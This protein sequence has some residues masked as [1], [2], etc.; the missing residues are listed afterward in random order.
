[1]LSEEKARLKIIQQPKKFCRFI[2]GRNNN[3][4]VPQFRGTEDDLVEIIVQGENFQRD[5]FLL[6]KLC[7][8]DDDQTPTMYEM[9]MLISGK[10]QPEAVLKIMPNETVSFKF[11]VVIK[12]REDEVDGNESEN[13]S[14]IDVK[15][16]KVYSVRV[17]LWAQ[18]SA[19]DG[20]VSETAT[21]FTNSIYNRDCIKEDCFLNH[22]NG[23]FSEDVLNLTNALKEF[24]M[25]SEAEPFVYACLPLLRYI[26][27]FGNTLLHLAVRNRQPFALRVVLK[28]LNDSPDKTNI[29]N[30]KNFRKQTALHLAVRCGESDCVHY[31]MAAGAN[32]SLLDGNGCTV[33]HYLSSTFNEDIY[34]DILFPPINSEA[35]KYE[36]D[37]NALNSEGLSAIHIAVAKKKL[38]LVEALI[39]AG[40]SVQQ[41][42]A[43]RNISLIHEAVKLNDIDTI[44]LLLKAGSCLEEKNSSGQTA[45]QL[46]LEL[47]H[48]EAAETLQAYAQ[49][50]SQLTSVPSTSSSVPESNK[51]NDDA[52]CSRSLITGIVAVDKVYSKDD[53]MANV[54][55]VTR[56]R[57]SQ[58][59]D[60]DERW[61]KLAMQINC[62]HM[63]EF[64]DVCYSVDQTSPTMLLLDQYEQMEAAMERKK[65]TGKTVHR[66]LREKQAKLHLFRLQ[67][68]QL[69]FGNVKRNPPSATFKS[70]GW[71]YATE[72]QNF[73]KQN[74]NR[75]SQ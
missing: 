17:K 36:L 18:F 33:A 13:S 38:C 9:N 15:N 37:L 71:L 64:I 63:V 23:H 61:K 35:A 16:H 34:K 59:L 8:D 6:L 20:E 47:N 7:T 65:K 51:F 41:H 21:I 49:A 4:N 73:S 62:S 70:F 10:I 22:S 69:R 56:L 40:A 11:G 52:E 57:L 68:Y 12:L 67:K 29:L 50:S 45:L 44:K 26:D 42:P 14:A 30:H 24:A 53:S 72:R 58:R 32:R 19:G 43:E 75:P 55:Y 54:D 27:E 66:R 5:A 25:T 46:A 48:Q 60:R 1:M 3:N 28:V 2:A 74:D 39:E 31:L